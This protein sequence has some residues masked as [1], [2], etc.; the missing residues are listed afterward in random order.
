M[1]RLI[2][3]QL[4]VISNPPASKIPTIVLC[5]SSTKRRSRSYSQDTLSRFSRLL[6]KVITVSLCFCSFVSSI[7]S[8][9]LATMPKIRYLSDMRAA[10]NLRMS[11]EQS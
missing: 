5:T 3:T 1:L 6:V 2:N 11:L 4:Q 8:R 10:S 7:T 9:I